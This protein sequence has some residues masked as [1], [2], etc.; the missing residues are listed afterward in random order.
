[1]QVPVS[2]EGAAILIVKFSD[3]QCPSCAQS[4]LDYKDILARYQAQYPGA[5]R[6]VVKDYPLETECNSNVTRDLHP[7]SCEAAAAARL[8][9]RKGVARPW[10][11]GC[12]PTTRR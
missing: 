7:A 4:Y 8:R 2:A 9:A 12:S 5:I 3:F 1:M 10:R 11:T 6:V